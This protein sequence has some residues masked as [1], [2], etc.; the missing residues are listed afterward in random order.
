MP[1]YLL[2]CLLFFFSLAAHAAAQSDPVGLL[3][4][5]GDPPPG[6]VFEVAERDPK[7]LEWAIPR[8]Q[9]DAKRLRE[10]FPGLPIAV[11]T[12][13]NEEFA[14]QTKKRG[15]NEAVHESVRELSQT[16][17]IP[18]HVCEAN[19]ERKGVKAEDFPDYVNVSPFGPEQIRQYKDL[20]YV[21]VRVR[22]PAP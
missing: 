14:L 3:L 6:V 5:R 13:G 20:G 1:R 16:E 4:Q 7:A 17:K 8:I 12:H 19:A 9:A 21:H 10:R 22:K 18:V 2:A 15:A 11:V